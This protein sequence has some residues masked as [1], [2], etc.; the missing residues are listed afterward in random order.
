MSIIK[1]K[2]TYLEMFSPPQFE[3]GV[4][5]TGRKVIRLPLPSVGFYRR[6][7]RAIGSNFHWIDRLLMPEDDLRAIIQDDLVDIFVLY[8][9][10]EPIGYSELDRRVC[11]EIEL[12]YFGLFPEVIGQGLGKYLLN[13][14]LRTAWSHRPRRVWVHTCDL[15]HPAA[16]PNYLKSGFQIYDESIVEQPIFSMNSTLGS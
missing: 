12:A 15:D 16:L 1:T 8:E 13:W 5:Q 10:Q 2:T 4:L 6:L 14:T 9:N 7:Y 3:V 11:N